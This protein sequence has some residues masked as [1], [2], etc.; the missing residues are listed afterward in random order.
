MV[1]TRITDQIIAAFAEDTISA[2]MWV[3]R[4]P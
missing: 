1:G 2:G 4:R 3:E